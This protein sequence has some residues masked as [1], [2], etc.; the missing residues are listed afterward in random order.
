[1]HIIL[2]IT[3]TAGLKVAQFLRS[4]SGTEATFTYPYLNNLKKLLLEVENIRGN[5]FLNYFIGKNIKR[6]TWDGDNVSSPTHD[7]LFCS[8]FSNYI[9][10]DTN[11]AT[12]DYDVYNSSLSVIEKT[13]PLP[14]A[15]ARYIIEFNRAP[16]PGEDLNLFISFQGL[17]NFTSIDS[18]LSN[19]V[20]GADIQG[21]NEYTNTTTL[22]YAE[23]PLNTNTFTPLQ[24]TTYAYKTWDGTEGVYGVRIVPVPTTGGMIYTTSNIT[25]G[26]YIMMTCDSTYGAADDANRSNVHSNIR[27][28]RLDMNIQSS[29]SYSQVACFWSIHVSTDITGAADLFT[30]RY[31]NGSSAAST[32]NNSFAIFKKYVA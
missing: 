11:Y 21:I 3:N 27:V 30:I 10:D 13:G 4:Y 1:L 5:D 12:G 9:P 15:Y 17:A 14:N 29:S 7:E 26:D 6:V 8:D 32:A 24:P 2:N 25:A 19:A 22:G 18:Y 28:E 31:A 16:R 23:P 20:T